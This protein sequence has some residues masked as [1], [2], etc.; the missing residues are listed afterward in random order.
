MSKNLCVLAMMMVAVSGA[1]AAAEAETGRGTAAEQVLEGH[2][3]PVGAV[4]PGNYL[5]D[6]ECDIKNEGLEPLA[7]NAALM[8]D[9]VWEKGEL[10][11][12]RIVLAANKESFFRPTAGLF[13]FFFQNPELLRNS[14]LMANLARLVVNHSGLDVRIFDAVEERLLPASSY[15]EFLKAV[16]EIKSQQKIYE[17]NR[18]V[19]R[20]LNTME[21]EGAN[22]SHLLWVTDENIGERPADLTFFDFA[23]EL[24][25]G[26]HTTFS[27]LAYGELPNWA[28]I[29]AAL[30]KR[31]GNSY[32]AGELEKIPE[33]VEKDLGFFRRPAVESVQV[34]IDLTRQVTEANSFYSAD[35]YGTIPSFYPTF[36]NNRPRTLHFLGGMNY[37]ETKRFIHYI[38]IP[39]YMDLIEA[40]L[41]HPLL[42]GRNF[43]I[44]RIFI[45]Y[46]LPMSDNWVYLQRD[47]TVEY[48]DADAAGNIVINAMVELDTIIQNTPLIMLEVARLVNNNRDYLLALKLL[49]AQIALLRDLGAERPDAAIDEDIKTL[50]RY[51][52]IVFEQ[53]KAVN[54]LE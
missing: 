26:A 45:R 5:S 49:Q 8:Q 50:E 18:L 34:I 35:Y 20:V 47:L 41:Q 7:V 37:G 21:S 17:Q 14:S 53:A 15:S 23:V 2:L 28:S 46:Y 25:A 12:F 13:V 9:R 44:G 29:N 30:I 31:N 52:E 36:T 3:L 43:T 38:N 51:Y 39:T 19:Q 4:D 10:T 1:F 42:K 11:S 32:Y 40:P 6:F 16:D 22:R 33:K 48:V 27:Y 54:L 24:L